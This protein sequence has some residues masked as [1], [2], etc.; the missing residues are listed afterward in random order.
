[1]SKE[2]EVEIEVVIEEE[3]KKRRAGRRSIAEINAIREP[4]GFK[5]QV[6]FDD[7][8]RDRPNVMLRKKKELRTR[9]IL[10]QMLS[11]KSRAVVN[12]IIDKAL[13]DEDSDQM[14]CLKIIAD[15]VVPV[16]YF[17]K[18]KSNAR[19]GINIQI[20]GVGGETIQ[21]MGSDSGIPLENDSTLIEGELVD[22]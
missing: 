8:P 7:K 11:R 12:K 3:P 17:T 2:N 9:E 6:K 5:K 19:N 21:V 14:A 4:L 13:D 1:M 18:D 20:V 10:A 22:E 15:R 16:D